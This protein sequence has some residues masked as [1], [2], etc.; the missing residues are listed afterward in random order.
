MTVT[1]ASI[2]FNHDPASS[3]RGAL[4][5]RRNG[6]D[7]GRVPEWIKGDPEVF[8]AAYAISD[9]LSARI[10]VAIDLLGPSNT[11]VFV[12]AVPTNP[13]EFNILGPTETATVNFAANGK[14]NGLRL[15]LQAPA[16]VQTGVGAFDVNWTWQYKESFAGPWND[17]E[18]TR[19]RIYVILRQ[20]TRP[21]VQTPFTAANTQLPWAE[22]LEWACR[23]AAFTHTPDAAAT[24]ITAAVYNL[25][26]RRVAYD[27]RGGNP[28]NYSFPEFDCSAFLERLAGEYGRGPRVNCTDCATIVSTFANVLGAD[29]WQSRMFNQIVPFRC[30]LMRPIGAPFFGPVCGTGFFNYHE[31]A[32]EGACSDLDEVYDAC[33]AVFFPAPPSVGLSAFMPSDINFGWSYAS[34]YRDFLVSPESRYI[35]QA[36]PTTRRRRLVY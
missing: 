21:W 12:R 4:N 17:F 5:I 11:R 16:L 15:T 10:D 14:R 34:S 24:A 6:S 35:C 20:P 3:R 9:A 18:T 28:T 30:N 32:W 19:H 27:C 13:L 23:W 22:V 25:G 29:L 7:P 31:V 36:Q 26:P 2:T 8:P 1:L 33:V